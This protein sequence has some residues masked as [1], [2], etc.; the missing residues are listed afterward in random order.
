MLKVNDEDPKL[1]E[2][3]EDYKIPEV[4]ELAAL[5]NWVHRLP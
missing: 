2:Y 1:I 3:S 5:E 4:G